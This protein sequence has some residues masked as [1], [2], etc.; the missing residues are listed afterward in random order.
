MKFT[1]EMCK[2]QYTKLLDQKSLMISTEIL[3]LHLWSD[4]SSNETKN[5]ILKNR[6]V[7]IQIEK[8]KKTNNKKNKTK[9]KTKPKK[10]PKPKPAKTVHHTVLL[11]CCNYFISWET[12]DFCK[13]KFE[14]FGIDFVH[15]ASTDLVIVVI[16]S[17]TPT[18]LVRNLAC[19]L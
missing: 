9:Q 16:V 18:L 3:S 8:K 11:W 13:P 4:D 1:A 19:L 12:G 5:L 17:Y 14:F 6:T 15:S 2:L 7:H 10:K